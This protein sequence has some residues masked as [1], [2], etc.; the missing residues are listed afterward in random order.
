MKSVSSSSSFQPDIAPLPNITGVTVEVPTEGQS[1]QFL[2]QPLPPPLL[3]P[4]LLL[5]LQPKLVACLQPAQC[6]MAAGTDTTMQTLLSTFTEAT[7]IATPI[8][9]VAILRT[10]SM[11]VAT[12]QP[13]GMDIGEISMS[14]AWSCRRASY[15]V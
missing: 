5:F 6:D 12:D 2:L 8:I 4:P 7:G 15:Q 10:V 1:A 3:D 13:T 14:A 9:P 11:P